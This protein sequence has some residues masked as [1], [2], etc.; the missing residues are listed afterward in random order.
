MLLYDS[1]Q[2]SNIKSAYEG[3]TAPVDT[4]RIYARSCEAVQ[5]QSISVNKVPGA[6]IQCAGILSVLSSLVPSSCTCHSFPLY[7]ACL[8]VY[9]RACTGT[10]VLLC[11]SSCWSDPTIQRQSNMSSLESR[12]REH[13]GKRERENSSIGIG[14]VM[15]NQPVGQ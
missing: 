12:P 13:K 9:V 1:Q 3:I 10:N 5:I 4:C 6:L 14:P 2:I 11:I 15:D 8:F 7:E